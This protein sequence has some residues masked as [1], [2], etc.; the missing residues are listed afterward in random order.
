MCQTAPAH[1]GER[2]GGRAPLLAG[3]AGDSH[4]VPATSS[5]SKTTLELLPVGASGSNRSDFALVTTDVLPFLS[6]FQE[7]L[8][9]TGS[10][11][12]LCHQA[13]TALLQ[14]LGRVAPSVQT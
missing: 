12:Q 9:K 7:C 6:N 11:S 10:V 8:C 5:H 3:F 2:E 4:P 1:L 14:V 13:I